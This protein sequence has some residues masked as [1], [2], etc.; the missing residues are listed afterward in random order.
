MKG[1]NT[2]LRAPI[3]Y[4]RELTGGLL[5][6]APSEDAFSVDDERFFVSTAHLV[7]QSAT[8]ALKKRE[9]LRRHYYETIGYVYAVTG[10]VASELKDS[11]TII[12]GTARQALDSLDPKSPRFQE[13]KLIYEQALHADEHLDE[14]LGFCYR[15][16]VLELKAHNLNLLVKEIAEV[17]RNDGLPEGVELVVE[18]EETPLPVACDDLQ[19]KRALRNVIQNAMRATQL[20]GGG[21][22]TVMTSV[23]NGSALMRVRNMGEPIAQELWEEIF[24][25]RF[26][27]KPV[28]T[29]SYQRS[30]YGLPVARGILRSHG[31]NVE[32]ESSQARQG[33]TFLITLPID[34]SQSAQVGEDMRAI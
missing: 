3:S 5:C 1:V 21:M 17:M 25:P 24:K 29:S 10:D 2:I 18:L 16:D 31:G 12:G 15:T 4:E 7:S 34:T 20:Q 19:L 30:G 13:L 11:L 22:V 27:S 9:A 33:T 23:E 6:G 8:Y 32:V 26:T 14:L 28:F